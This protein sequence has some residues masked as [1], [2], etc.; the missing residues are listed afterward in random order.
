MSFL[1][2][3]FIVHLLALMTPGPD[4]LIVTKTAM[5]ASRRAAF[6]TAIG[7]VLGVAMWASLVLL[8]LHLVF[9]KLAW[10]QTVV[11]IAGG[12]YLVYLGFLMLKASFQKT[13]ATESLSAPVQMSD[14]AAL[15]SGFLTNLANP[16]AAIYFGSIFATFLTSSTSTID[17]LIMFFMVTGESLAWFW[18][19]GFLFSLPAPRRAYQ[20]ANR[21]IDRIAGT[22]FS[23]FG[24][25]LILTS[26]R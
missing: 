6:L 10:L 26:T 2:P 7:V 16:K 23:L 5:S 18:F 11:K 13:E 8:G 24:L 22:A 4:F 3:L 9:E 1:L 20:R 14:R 12:A 21:W 25:R 15:R 17:K 19:L